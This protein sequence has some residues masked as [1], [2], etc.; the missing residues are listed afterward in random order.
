MNHGR[1]KSWGAI[2]IV[3]VVTVLSMAFVGT[4]VPLLEYMARSLGATAEAVGFALALFS[5]PSALLAGIGGGLIDRAGARAGLIVGGVLAAIADALI[6]VAPSIGLLDAAF[7]ISGIGFAA[8]TVAGPALIMEITSGPRRF[9]AMSVWSTYPPAGLSAGLLIAAPFADAA[10]WRWALAAH[11]LLIAAATAACITLPRPTRSTGGV[12]GHGGGLANLVSAFL[13][14]KVLRLAIAACLPAAIAYGTTLIVPSYLA[15]A[16]Q[17]SLSTS[18]RIVA[19]SNLATILGGLAAG[20]VLARNASPLFLYGVTVAAGIASQAMIFIPGGGFPLAIAGLVVW[21]FA[22]GGSIAITMSLLP[23]V[24]RDPARGAA[25][26]G[27]VGQFISAASFLVPGLYF[28]VLA[29]G[30][31]VKFVLLAAVALAISLVALPAW[32]A[33][34][35]GDARPGIAPPV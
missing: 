8:I 5:A 15:N 27:L 17:L 21:T 26:S 1:R 23:H 7:L 35:S 34:G 20:H 11:G 6:S 2:G 31:A 12:S 9:Q 10:D 18:S 30:G 13:E 33:R 32:P 29:D 19:F 24:V 14:V 22:I 25:A 28:G 16:H 4:M 3:Y